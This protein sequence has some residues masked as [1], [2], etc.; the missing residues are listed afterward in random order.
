ME[1]TPT[2]VRNAVEDTVR[3]WLPDIA[4]SRPWMAGGSRPT[5]VPLNVFTE[6]GGED[7]VTGDTLDPN[8]RN[9]YPYVFIE[10][11]DIHHLR[12]ARVGDVERNTYDYF[13]SVRFYIDITPGDLARVPLL[14]K[15][16]QA[17]ALNFER[18]FQYVEI[19]GDPEETFNRRS[20]VQD[21]VLH[22]FMN[23]HVS[24]DTIPEERDKVEA[25][26]I[27]VKHGGE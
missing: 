10:I 13:I 7:S 21:G 20:T 3:K 17:M 27:V 19:F 8:N 23:L 4:I 22:F 9:I 18:I 11:L 12:R 16:M 5:N 26:D 24:E 2:S 1:L 6:M 15:E 25:V 14:Q